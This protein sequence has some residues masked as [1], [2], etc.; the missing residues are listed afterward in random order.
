[1]PDDYRWQYR[2]AA[3]PADAR[4]IPSDARPATCL[5]GVKDGDE[6]DVDCGGSC[7][8]CGPHKLCYGDFDCSVTAS[9][10]EPATGGCFCQYI[11]HQCVFDHCYDGKISGDETD[12]DCGGSM[13]NPCVNGLGCRQNS[14]CK[15]LACDGVTFLCIL[16][17]CFDRKQDGAES[18]IDCGGINCGP[19]STGRKC[20][21]SFDCQSGHTCLSTHVCS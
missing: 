4:P 14:D 1:M 3:S 18:D 2:D 19:C 16:N 11:T 10:C 6:S 15:S 12:V 13:C 17:L 5:D 21:S 20:G 9:G 8:G 7:D